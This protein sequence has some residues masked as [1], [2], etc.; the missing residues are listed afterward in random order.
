[1]T[2]LSSYQYQTIT[3]TNPKT[4][5]TETSVRGRRYNLG[6][7]GRERG[8]R[9]LL[10]PTITDHIRHL[11][12][13]GV[14]ERP[15]AVPPGR[16]TDLFKPVPQFHNHHGRWRCKPLCMKDIYFVYPLS[17]YP[18]CMHRYRKMPSV[19]VGFPTMAAPAAWQQAV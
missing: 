11:P 15:S 2:N 12:E 18:G 16:M 13:P 7:S 8:K 17:L 6:N 14:P 5:V 3:T 9:S 1:M 10:Q 19:T 4:G